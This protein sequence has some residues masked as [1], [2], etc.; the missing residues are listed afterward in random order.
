M[1]SPG[2]YH[3][4][5]ATRQG[6]HNDEIAAALGY[7]G[8]LVTGHAIISCVLDHAQACWP[9]R[10]T[11]AGSLRMWFGRPVYDGDDMYVIIVDD[12]AVAVTTGSADSSPR[13]TGKI[14]DLDESVFSGSRRTFSAGPPAPRW[15]TPEVAAT[16]DA[17]GSTDFVVDREACRA[18][19]AAIGLVP[20]D[21]GVVDATG[22]AYL[23]RH[24]VPHSRANFTNDQPI[25]HMGAELEWYR[26]VAF[27]E[28]IS[29]RGRVDRAYSRRGI[30]Y[31]VTELAWC[32]DTDTPVLRAIHTVIYAKAPERL[33]LAV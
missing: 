17:L 16:T 20:P 30:H 28:R 10:W 5:N 11:S 25:I 26:P 21:S 14:A 22:L 2:R 27:G 23:Y 15:L 33:R 18:Q 6:I 13:A 8:G 9:G 7:R 1:R 12:G 3:A 32:D 24:Y 31:L 4:V 29:V 19:L